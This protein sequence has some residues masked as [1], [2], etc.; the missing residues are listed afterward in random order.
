V[1]SDTTRCPFCA[2]D[3]AIAPA[4]IVPASTTTLSRAA[5]FTFA[6]TLA[7]GCTS[8][9][10]PPVEPAPT[11]TPAPVTPVAGPQ[12][13]GAPMAI[14]GAPAAFIDPA[15]AGAPAADVPATPPVDVP[16]VDAGRPP[17]PPR[18]NGSVGVRYGSPPRPED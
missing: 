2:A 5:A 17:R 6:T 18:P 1:R 15:D 9:Q 13:P 10:Q 11:V 16:A 12:D 4:S 7:L 14:Y 8:A 3:V